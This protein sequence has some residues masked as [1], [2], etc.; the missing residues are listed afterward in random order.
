MAW[1]TDEFSIFSVVEQ[2]T[3]AWLMLSTPCPILEVVVTS[4]FF[5]LRECRHNTLLN[6]NRRFINF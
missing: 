4:T 6:G 2:Q 1:E 5:R 3:F